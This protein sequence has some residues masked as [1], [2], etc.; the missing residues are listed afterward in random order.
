[1]TMYYNEVIKEQ[2]LNDLKE[3]EGFEGETLK[4][5]ANVFINSKDIEEVLEKDLYDFTYDEIKELFLNAN[6]TSYASIQAFANMTKRYI[7]WAINMGLVNS[8]INPVEMFT[9]DDLMSC[10][11]KSVKKYFAE[12]EINEIEK[13]L[14]NYQDVVVIRLPF[15]GILGEGCDEMLNLSIDDVDFENNIVYIRDGEEVKRRVE[16][17]DHCLNIIEKAANEQEYLSNNNY[18]DGSTRGKE[19]YELMKSDKIIRNTIAPRTKGN[20][21]AQGIYRRIK[22][23]KEITGYKYLSLKNIH[24]SGMIKMAVELLDKYDN[25]ITPEMLDEIADKFGLSKMIVNGEIAYN[26]FSMRQYI[27]KET[28]KKLYNINIIN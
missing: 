19:K 8:N 1:M 25:K 21:T 3:R 6:R 11:N 12:K 13:L 18:Y 14:I 4:V 17:S 24:R 26:H 7:E 28:I 10:V 2:F 16:I 23:I 15:E 22:A 5:Y 9:R 27:N 20:M